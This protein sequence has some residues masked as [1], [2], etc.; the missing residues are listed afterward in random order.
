MSAAA[1]TAPQQLPA[2]R[3][4]RSYITLN[5]KQLMTVESVSVD[6]N[7]R[8]QADTFR[9]RA[10]ISTDR[11]Q[12][13]TALDNWAQLQAGARIEVYA[14]FPPDPSD[15]GPS[16]LQRLIVGN[17]DELAIS[18]P[19]N[20]VELF[21]RDLSAGL[22]DTKIIEKYQNK[23]ASDIA[24]LLAAEH[25]L[26]T[27]IVATTTKVGTYYNNDHVNLED[28]R[29][30]W[31]LLTYLAE[32]EGYVVYVDG[33]TLHFEPNTQ[34]QAVY[35]VKV[36]YDESGMLRSD[37]SRV[38]VTRNLTLARDIRVTVRSWRPDTAKTIVKT[39]IRPRVRNALN[40]PASNVPPQVYTFTIPNLMP[41]EAQRRA[42]QILLDLS[43]K[44]LVLNL[45]LPGDATLTARSLI[46]LQG[47]G[48]PIDADY[49]PVS[50]T[51]AFSVRDGYVMRVQ[52]KNHIPESIIVV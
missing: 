30:E 1:M 39:A 6:N 37:A 14:G 35:P 16:T 12:M 42:N 21:G 22:L 31:G 48:S 36:W 8:S 47:T 19:T 24:A 20:S 18:P 38:S 34:I 44:E 2:A 9:I 25:G 5:G 43:A 10:P 50:V 40:P 49:W 52:A 13:A 15:I 7:V 33:A 26:H 28:D 45:T 27:A 51:R 32:R 4:P 17:I 11:N 3:R 23:T 46:R 29:S 41:D